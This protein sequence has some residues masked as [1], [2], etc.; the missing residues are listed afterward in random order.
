MLPI[1]FSNSLRILSGGSS[2]THFPVRLLRVVLLLTGVLFEGTIDL[3]FAHVFGLFRGVEGRM[4]DIRDCK[5]LAI[6]ETG[7]IPY[8]PDYQPLALWHRAG[9][10]SVK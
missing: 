8:P 3:R 1:Q 9:T 6:M 10:P 4:N 5:R 2:T 7:E